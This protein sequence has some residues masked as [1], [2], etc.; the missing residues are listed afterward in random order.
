MFEN[1]PSDGMHRMKTQISLHI[2]AVW[3][4]FKICV[5]KLCILGYPKYAQWRFWSDFAKE[6]AGPQADLNFCWAHIS[7][8]TEIAAYIF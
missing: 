1:V 5:K 7:K 8:G 3:S 2:R 4:V 6:K